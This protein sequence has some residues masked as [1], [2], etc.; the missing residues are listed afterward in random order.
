MILNEQSLYEHIQH[1]DTKLEHDHFLKKPYTA[2]KITPIVNL[3]IS[4]N[5]NTVSG[6]GDSAFAHS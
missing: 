3:D 2:P 1:S 6:D 5:L 4:N